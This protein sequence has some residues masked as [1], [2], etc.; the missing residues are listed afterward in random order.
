[1]VPDTP[2]NEH[3]LWYQYYF[4]SERGRAGLAADRRGLCKLLWQLWSPTW[5]V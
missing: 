2:E 5:R 4:H 3:R 1:M